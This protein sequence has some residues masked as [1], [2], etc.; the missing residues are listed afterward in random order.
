[1]SYID[2]KTKLTF[3]N[4]FSKN[5][6]ITED[7]HWLWIGAKAKGYGRFYSEVTKRSHPVHRLILMVL[8]LLD[9]ETDLLALHKRECDRKD[10]FNPQHLYAGTDSNNK[11]DSI[12]CKTHNQSSK[13]HC[14]QGH[15]YN[16]ENTYKEKGIWNSRRCR[17]CMKIHNDL[18]NARARTTRL[19]GLK[20]GV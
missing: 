2:E 16:E 1:M 9:P 7:G 5:R 14:P 11:Y 4:S 17:K 18:V 13:T 8:E 6:V 15:E 19:A 3:L 10:C 20:Q 12:E